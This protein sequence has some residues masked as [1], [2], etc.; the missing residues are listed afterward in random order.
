MRYLAGCRCRRC[1][2][3]NVD[4]KLRQE[5]NRKRFGLNNLVPVGP[6]RAFLLAMQKRGIGYKTIAKQVGVGKTGLGILI[7]PGKEIKHFMRRLTA[8]KVLGYIPALDSMPRNLSVP[9]AETVARVRQLERWGY[10]RSLIN[11][12]ALGNGSDGLQTHAVRGTGR[13]VVMVKTAIRIRDFFDQILA[14]REFWQEK[15]GSIPRRHYVYWKKGTYGTTIRSLEL[16]PFARSHDFHYLFPPE[17]R[18]AI[19]LTNRVKHAYRKRAKDAKKHTDRPSQPSVRYAGSAG[20][21][22]EAA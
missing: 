8:L 2:K 13:F 9:A 14:I 3:A 10:P 19:I 21:S 12:E 17:L 18:E 4:C 1:R 7:W 20:R 6:V 22:R 15:R 11:H 16:R 5:E